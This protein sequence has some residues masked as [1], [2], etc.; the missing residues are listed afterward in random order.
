VDTP[1]PIELRDDDGRTVGWYLTE[2][3]YRRLKACEAEVEELRELN[4]IERDSRKRLHRELYNMLKDKLPL[5]EW[6]ALPVEGGLL[7]EDCLREL[8]AELAPE[9]GITNGPGS[10]PSAEPAR[11]S[12]E[13]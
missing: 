4:A 10:V 9:P 12:Q 5:D 6:D 1:A 7:F 13:G 3:E 8:E 11:P 2:A